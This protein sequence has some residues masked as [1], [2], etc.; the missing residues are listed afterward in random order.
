MKKLFY[1]I[2]AAVTVVLAACGGNEPEPS[3]SK[4]IYAA[5]SDGGATITLYYD[6]LYDS[7]SGVDEN[8]SE[9]I[10]TSEMEQTV[11]LE[12]TK[13]VLDISM[14]E[15][16]PSVTYN[17]F[18][19]WSNMTTIEHLDY[20]N[21][22]NVT[23]MESMFSACT[24]LTSLDLTSFNMWKVENTSAMFWYCYNLET[25][26][27]HGEWDR[28]PTI[29]NSKDM[30]FNCKKLAGGKGTNFDASHVGIA[31]ARPD[32]GSSKPG[33]FTGV[34]RETYALYDAGSATLTVCFKN[35]KESHANAYS[36][37]EV[38]PDDV[39]IAVKKVKID[40]SMN[41]SYDTSL[42][43]WFANMTELTEVT[44][45]E[46]FNMVPIKDV[47]YL[48]MGCTSLETIDINGFDISNVTTATEL[49]RN[50]S[51]LTTIYCNTDYSAR[52]FNSLNMFR[53]CTALRGDAGTTYDAGHTDAQYARLDK[54]EA[55]PGY[56]SG[57]RVYAKLS[58]NG[59]TMTLYYDETPT[60]HPGE[61]STWDQ[62]EGTPVYSPNLPL[63]MQQEE[64]MKKITKAVLD[65]S[66]K[67]ARPKST[68]CWFAGLSNMTQIEH[69]D[70]LNTEEVIS[71]GSMFWCCK[72]LTELDLSAFNVQNVENTM[73]MFYGCSSL[74]TIYCNDDW[75]K[76]SKIAEGLNSYYAMYA[77]GC[78]SLVGGKG[79]TMPEGAY[80]PL[81]YSHP[82][83]GPSNPG[84]FTAK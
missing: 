72:S 12:I 53:G 51:S 64:W 77:G 35:D 37:S 78:S 79:T 50:C 22:S 42:K 45:L 26:Y 70:Y 15:A 59:Q 32:K 82:D 18:Y 43:L 39:R 56:F 23:R 49:F 81:D 44:G 73:F 41:Q 20:L 47:S 48:F 14:K 66:M 52:E 1:F 36:M 58:D 2:L 28:I 80:D 10:G 7:R 46:N 6:N 83:G 5:L 17:W 40:E 65:G 25:I 34:A 11:R 19:G 84:F 71:M 38:L 60:A 13:A 3:K 63:S 54:G 75:K 61:M 76:S 68:A 57:P 74:K 33:Y 21:T 67:Q 16:R 30:F 69:L 8:W 27:C 29:T 31:Y 62:N 9:F 55:A 4:K 24:K